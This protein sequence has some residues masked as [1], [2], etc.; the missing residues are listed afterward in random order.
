MISI[1]RYQP[2]WL[3]IVTMK[4]GVT[5]VKNRFV[6]INFDNTTPFWSSENESAN[7]IRCDMWHTAS[8][9]TRLGGRGTL[10]STSLGFDW[11][12]R[13]FREYCTLL[14]WSYGSSVRLCLFTL[15]SHHSQRG[16]KWMVPFSCLHNS[17]GYHI[18]IF[19]CIHQ[20]FEE[21]MKCSI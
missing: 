2:M 15:S 10:N 14:G 8:V 16:T 21:E 17:F 19:R 5:E 3:T 11:N 7:N 18:S 1:V 9:I 6:N 20:L 13:R 12:S 4:L